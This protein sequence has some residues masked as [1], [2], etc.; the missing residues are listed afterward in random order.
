MPLAAVTSSKLN[1]TVSASTCQS[2]PP[3][4]EVAV[5]VARESSVKSMARESARQLQA[6]GCSVNLA[7]L[8]G[9]AG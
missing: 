6:E 9:A 3:P 8:R 2:V 1:R 7:M 5:T 4:V